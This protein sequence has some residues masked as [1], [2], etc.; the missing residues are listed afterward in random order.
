MISKG[1]LAIPDELLDKSFFPN[2]KTEVKPFEDILRVTPTLLEW[3]RENVN[4]GRKNFMADLSDALRI[5]LLADRGGVYLGNLIHI[6]FPS[7][8]VYYQG[9]TYNTILSYI[10][11][12]MISLKPMASIPMNSLGKQMATADKKGKVPLL[13]G[14]ALIF[15]K[16]NSFITACINKFNESYNPKKFGSVGPELLWNVYN[17][18]T[19]K[20][21][22]KS[23]PTILE[24]HVFY[25]IKFKSHA[26]KAF[27]GN[28]APV[29]VPWFHPQTVG[30]HFWGHL[31]T[32]FE[33]S[34]E[35]KGGKILSKCSD[36]SFLT[37]LTAP[38][39]GPRFWP[40]F[41]HSSFFEKEKKIRHSLRRSP[42]PISLE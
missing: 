15:E 27:F 24:N 10:D 39:Y 5:A 14:A 23:L 25:P 7:S 4:L 31:S 8:K 13:N 1:N 19:K 12:D 26:L 16:N 18:L 9:N 11:T 32:R 28:I 20:I 40:R 34:P 3:Y 30:V 6:V 42:V 38:D 37:T 22:L 36:V 33:I 41:N 21:D 2:V 29:H 17:D 35:S